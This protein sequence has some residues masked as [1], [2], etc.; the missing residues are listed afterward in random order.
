MGLV[1]ELALGHLGQRKRQTLVSVAGV[2]LGVG[3]FIGMMA[4]MGGFQKYFITQVIDSWPHI[5]IKDE[6]REPALQPVFRVY[7]QGAVQLVSLKPRDELKGIRNAREILAALED[8]PYASA[9]TLRTQVFYRYGSR[10]VAATL[11]GI[12]PKRE[13]QVTQLARDINQGSLDALYSTANG[14]ILGEGLAK[15][16][17]VGLGDMLSVTSPVGAVL[18]MKVVGIF[19]TGV[20]ALDNFESYSLIKKAQVLAARANV[21]NQVRLRIPDVSVARQVAQELENRFGYKAESWEESYSNVLGLFKVQN[22][23]M[24]S[25]VGA[26]LVVAAFGIFNIISTVINEKRRDIAIL[27]SIGLSEGDIKGV[28]MI[29]GLILGLVGTLLGWALGYGLTEMLASIRF[30]MEGFVRTQGFILDRGLKPY[31]VAALFAMLSATFAAWLP[32]RKAARLNP[33]DIIRGAA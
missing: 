7:P 2:A 14:V 19:N 3:F 31:G 12:D 32:A 26:I 11:V 9:P 24:Y 33:V 23:V 27:K 29:Q 4:L 28:F 18:K 6:F 16:L 17:G 21:I 10:E 20:T 22:G 25:A 15:K 5:I 13:M 1:L 30:N 8:S